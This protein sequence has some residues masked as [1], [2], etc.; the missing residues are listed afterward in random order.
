MTGFAYRNFWLVITVILAGA[1]LAALVLAGV[2]GPFPVSSRTIALATGAGA[3]VAAVLTVRKGNAGLPPGSGWIALAAAGGWAFALLALY[4]ISFYL[5]FPVD[6]LN[7]W[8][9]DFIADIIK[10][11]AGLPLYTEPTENNSQVYTPGAQLLTYSIGRLAGVETSIPALRTIQFSY[12]I[13]AAV[14]ATSACDHLAR[15]T[16]TLDVPLV[17]A[18]PAGRDGTAIRI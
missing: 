14:V 9:G 4:N 3:A 18:A 12:A 10:L 17:S 1:M 15:R 8:E 7:F 5:R 2:G 6:F 16:R 13:L 11:R